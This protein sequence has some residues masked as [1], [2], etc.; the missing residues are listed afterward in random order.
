MRL[1][2]FFLFGSAL[3]AQSP[4]AFET[5]LAA[6][7]AA[8][9]QSRYSEADVQLRAAVAELA[10]PDPNRPPARAADGYAALC[11]LD[12]LMSRYDEAISLAGKAVDVIDALPNT[13]VTPHLAR[14]A[15]AYR[16]AGQTVNAI[17]VLTRMLTTDQ[18]LGADDLK[19]SVDYDKLGSAYLELLRMEEA[20]DCY[21]KA[22]E[23]ARQIQLGPGPYRRSDG[24]GESKSVVEQRNAEAGCGPG[25]L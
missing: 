23:A 3:F 7:Q 20:R 10:R 12:L 15:S 19:V 14:L 6:G 18:L 1:T 5:H 21:Q 2:T 4:S 9:Q 16:V 24:L 11:D 25:R 13:D 22:V 8:I 17:P